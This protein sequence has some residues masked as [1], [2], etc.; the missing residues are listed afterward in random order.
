MWEDVKYTPGTLKVVAKKDGKIWATDTVTTT[1]KPAALTLKP[2][3]NEIKGDGYD[4]SYV[5]VAVR[6]AQGRMVPRSKK[7]AHLQGKR[8]RGHRRHLQR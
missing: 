4:L 3:R 7:P 1:G 2:D 5:T 8:P 6:D